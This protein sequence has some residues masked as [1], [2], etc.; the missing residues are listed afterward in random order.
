[1]NKSDTL[2]IVCCVLIIVIA[3]VYSIMAVFIYKREQAVKNPYYFCDSTWKCCASEDNCDTTKNISGISKDTTYSYPSDNWK[4]GS[5]YHQNCVLPVQN[6]ILNYESTP[7]ARF[8]LGF[9]Y[10]GGTKPATTPSLYYPGCTG[11]GGTGVCAD[12]T[13]NPQNDVTGSLGIPCPYV[14]IDSGGHT[15]NYNNLNTGTSS[16]G[17]GKTLAPSAWS[18][19]LASPYIA[20]TNS[21]NFD[22]GSTPNNTYIFPY[23]TK[24]GA[25]FKGRYTGG[26][27]GTANQFTYSNTHLNT[28][29]DLTNSRA[30][31]GDNT[32]KNPSRPT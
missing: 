30:Y 28:F 25:S 7:N 13:L 3:I 20:G 2:F 24:N 14:S 1:M 26:A 4:P 17:S 29:Y 15:G 6:A 12:P 19:N 31:T 32:W 9:L 27:T 10:L 18:G 23:D 22:N 21:G 16:Y 5:L 8:E 11:H